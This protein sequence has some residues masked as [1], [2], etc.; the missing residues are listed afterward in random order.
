MICNFRGRCA[1]KKNFLTLYRVT[2]EQHREIGASLLV[3]EPVHDGDETIFKVAGTFIP[4]CPLLKC[5][6]YPP[7]ALERPYQPNFIAQAKKKAFVNEKSGRLT[8][9]EHPEHNRGIH[10]KTCPENLC[11]EEPF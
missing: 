5:N 3:S 10:L 2:N 11:I 1:L 6:Q 4:L 8:D 9:C 7:Y